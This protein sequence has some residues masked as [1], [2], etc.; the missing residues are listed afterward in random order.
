MN[1]DRREPD[2]R[3]RVADIHVGWRNDRKAWQIT[4]SGQPMASRFRIKEHAVAFARAVASSR[5]AE[6]VVS[7]VN[8]QVTRHRKDTLSYPTT[9][10]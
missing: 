2:A 9:L 3:D 5:D 1:I 10:D 8:G 7:E 6:L 4:R